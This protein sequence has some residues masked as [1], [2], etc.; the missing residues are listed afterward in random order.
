[1]QNDQ[2]SKTILQNDITKTLETISIFSVKQISKEIK[3]SLENK[4]P[5]VWVRGEVGP[6][7]F[8]SSGHTYFSLKEEDLTLNC[9]CWRGTPLSIQLEEGALIECY[10]RVTVYGGKSS[11][12]LIVREA[13]STGDQ[14]MILAKL[15]E[16]K[17]KLATEGLFES[18]RKKEIPK[19][20]EA[21]AILTSPTGA[22]FHDIMHRIEARFPCCK[23]FF[24]PVA[25]QG[26]SAVNDVIKGIEKA[27]SLDIDLIIL[28]RGGGS[29]E[30]LWAFNNEKMV[31]KVADTKKPII[32]AIGH[33]T[34]TTLVDFA[35]DLRAPTPTAAAEIA[36]P[37]RV[38]IISKINLI[39]QRAFSL[40]NERIKN[41]KNMLAAM[42]DF[43]FIYSNAIVIFAQK[44]DQIISNV[45]SIVQKRINNC[46]FELGALESPISSIQRLQFE[47]EQKIQNIT[48]MAKYRFQDAKKIVEYNEAMIKEKEEE[49]KE[50]VIILNK[51]NKRLKDA[52]EIMEAKNFKM[53]M[54]DGEIEAEVI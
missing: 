54:H 53:L 36:V 21:I 40:L 5:Y 18:S 34:D 51:E 35:S 15:E 41:E 49:M 17:K 9:I 24:I 6:I 48:N 33:E 26:D 30:D 31:R 14:G 45:I 4:F 43:N 19:I 38:Q 29:L 52:K 42:S 12:Q 39:S 11:Y 8:H 2:K 7:K 37:D 44:I 28:A 22:V 16:L 25:V 20:P 32:T 46:K 47:I 50:R 13:K 23:V 3:E 27:E 1:M 10:G